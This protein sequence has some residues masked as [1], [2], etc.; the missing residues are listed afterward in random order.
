MPMRMFQS[1][2]REQAYIVI[3]NYQLILR[4]Q[5]NI[6]PSVT[7]LLVAAANMS[8]LMWGQ[9]GKLAAERKPLRDS[10]GVEDTSPLRQTSMRNHYEHFDERLDEWWKNSKQHNIADRLI[11]PMGM[12][13]G[14]DP[15]DSFRQYDPTTGDLIFWGDR[16]NILKITEEA[17][18]LLPALEREASKPHWE[19]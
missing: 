6:W 18:R 16:F 2:L 3:G 17:L 12:I 5:T 19:P 10:I 13:G 9:A 14:I 8:K 4:D 15:L 1:H 7:A 11:G